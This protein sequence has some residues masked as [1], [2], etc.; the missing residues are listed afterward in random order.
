MFH[1]VLNFLARDPVA[2][3]ASRSTVLDMVIL[4]FQV[5]KKVHAFYLG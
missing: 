4:I 5:A 3:Y 1:N 2:Q